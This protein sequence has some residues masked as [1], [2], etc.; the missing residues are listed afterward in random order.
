MDVASGQEQA[1]GRYRTCY[2][3][4]SAQ[5]VPAP[6]AG[7]WEWDGQRLEHGRPEHG[8]HASSPGRGGRARLRRLE[9]GAELL[10]GGPV[11][12][13]RRRSA[14]AVEGLR[15]A[16]LRSG[17]GPA[18]RSSASNELSYGHSDA[19]VETKAE[20]INGVMTRKAILKSLTWP[21]LHHRHR[22]P[23]CDAHATSGCPRASRTRKATTTRISV[24][25]VWQK[26]ALGLRSCSPARRSGRRNRRN[27]TAQVQA[28]PSVDDGRSGGR[29]SE[30]LPDLGREP[31]EMLE[32]SAPR[33]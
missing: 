13:R 28:Q 16:T 21:D 19:R 6:V 26:Q 31:L 30:R 12:R 17:E 4:Y 5:A 24:L 22:G 32:R 20:F 1:F 10:S 8:D 23:Q 15:K 7:A 11:H 29:P 25:Q 33:R 18:R 2:G 9:P 27:A 14:K 3:R